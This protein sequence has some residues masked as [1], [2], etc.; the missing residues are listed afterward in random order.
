LNNS[1]APSRRS[2]KR[3]QVVADLLDLLPVLKPCVPLQINATATIAAEAADKLNLAY[4][5]IEMILRDHFNSVEYLSACAAP[6][7]QRHDVQTGDPWPPS[8]PMAAISV[9][10]LRKK[11]VSRF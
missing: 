10:L 2:L 4:G 9:Y 5:Q 7:A 6:R 8:R 1:E 3:Q 11:I